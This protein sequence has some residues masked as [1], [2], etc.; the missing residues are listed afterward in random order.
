MSTETLLTEIRDELRALRTVMAAGLSA[1]TPP[2]AGARSPAGHSPASSSSNSADVPPPQPATVMELAE[3]EC[4]TVHFGKN[5]GVALRDLSDRSV[6]YYAAEKEPRL[7]NS[8]KPFP[9]RP[10]EIA[11]ENAARTVWHAR[12]GSL[13]AAP[14]PPAAGSVDEDVPY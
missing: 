9:K 2:A 13:A 12:K 8:G 5:N 7:D 10:Q 1:Q 11:L 6:Q 3:A 14:T 4:T